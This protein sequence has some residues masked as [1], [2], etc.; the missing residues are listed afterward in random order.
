[1]IL[2][3]EKQGVGGH[4]GPEEVRVCVG[5]GGAGEN[6]EMEL[7]QSGFGQ[8][9]GQYFVAIER[10]S[11]NGVSLARLTGP[12]VW[13]RSYRAPSANRLYASLCSKICPPNLSSAT[14]RR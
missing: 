9:T 8:R 1:M 5:R 3:E 2:H 7:G 11:P 10:E 4:A 6:S 12:T 13:P 14:T